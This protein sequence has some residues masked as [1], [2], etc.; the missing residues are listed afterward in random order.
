MGAEQSEFDA[1]FTFGV[2][3]RGGTDKL[4]GHYLQ[5]HFK[6]RSEGGE[7]LLIRVPHGDIDD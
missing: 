3:P 4:P 2:E 7:G 6:G 5:C 1:S